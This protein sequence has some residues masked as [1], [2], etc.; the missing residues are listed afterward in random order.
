MRR[1]SGTLIA[2]AVSI[3][4]VITL[5]IGGLILVAQSNADLRHTLNENQAAMAVLVDQYADLY[6]QAQA[7]GVNPDAP[8]PE[9][10]DEVLPTPLSGAQGEPGR[11]P[12][13]FE[14]ATAVESYCDSRG[15][16]RGAPGPPGPSGPGGP[17]GPQGGAGERGSDGAQG[18]PGSAGANGKDG[19]PG[20]PPTAEEIASAVAAY[21]S[22]GA[23][24]GAKGDTGATGATGPGPTDDQIASA[25]MAYCQTTGCPPAQNPPPGEPES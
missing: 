14:I 5:V 6:A 13:G 4:A 24:Q 11:P 25:V 18:A 16:C 10:L 23:C 15:N 22:T 21:C 17:Q 19:A 8:E 7:E 12:T 20:R 9:K 1:P 2:T 3:A